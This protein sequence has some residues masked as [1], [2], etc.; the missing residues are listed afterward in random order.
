MRYK[1]GYVSGSAKHHHKVHI[2]VE[3]GERTSLLDEIEHAGGEYEARYAITACGLD[4]RTASKRS[5]RALVFSPGSGVEDV[6]CAHCLKK[7]RR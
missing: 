7:I 5:W 6:T 4:S 3:V 1:V 2:L